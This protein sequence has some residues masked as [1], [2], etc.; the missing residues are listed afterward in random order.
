MFACG[1]VRRYAAIQGRKGGEQ[2][3]SLLCAQAAWAG[4]ARESTV[5]ESQGF[6]VWGRNITVW[7]SQ[8]FKVLSLSVTRR[9][10]QTW[11]WNW[12]PISI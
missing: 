12:N 10:V 11:A 6:E 9:Y 7:G 2:E 1:W 3:A 8:G 5:W 4:E